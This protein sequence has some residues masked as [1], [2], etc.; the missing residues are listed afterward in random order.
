M[1]YAQECTE[2]P[3]DLAATR[4]HVVAHLSSVASSNDDPAE[5][6]DAVTLFYST[7]EKNDL[8]VI[9]GELNRSPE[10]PYLRKLT[11]DV[12]P[13]VRS[14]VKPFA[15][16]LQD[17]LTHYGIPWRVLPGA[18][19]RGNGQSWGSIAGGIMHHT[20]TPEGT[21]PSVLINGRSDLSGPLCNSAG[22]KD[23]TVAFV[24]Y[25][26]ANH[27]G[28]AGGKSMG[29]LPVTTTFNK[30][31]WGHEIVYPGT[32]PMNDAQYRSAVGLGR[33]IAD[34]CGG[35]EVVRAHA[36]TSVTGKWDPGY[37]P[38]KTIDM[39]AFRSAVRNLTLAK[40]EEDMEAK[41]VQQL[42]VIYDQITGNN[43]Q[44]WPTWPGGTTNP[45]GTPAKWTLVD[46]MRGIDV[47]VRLAI[48]DANA[49]KV[50][51]LL[52]PLITQAVGEALGGANDGLA[53]DIINRLGAK[54]AS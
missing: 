34:L 21:A 33:V 54:L 46:Y 2:S 32:T 28:A 9:T 30:R 10:A 24:A 47:S 29:P 14:T 13:T 27:A 40:A 8:V 15:E 48:G 22:E 12:R 45:D 50:A 43:F 3:A 25:N 19:N 51:A 4:A 5:F 42:Q 39:A 1:K 38:G 23:G 17:G 44:G 18:V 37:A 36:E 31:V 6:A 26:P 20:A 7:N 35:A 41:Q 16:L 53:E 11:A 52:G 49:K